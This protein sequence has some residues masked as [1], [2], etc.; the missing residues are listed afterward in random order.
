MTR[1][2]QEL[3]LQELMILKSE[4][5]SAEKST[6]LSYLMLLGGHLGIHRFYLKRPG[7]GAAQLALF[8]VATIFYFVMAIAS[9]TSNETLVILSVILFVLP[10]IALFIWIVV[11]LFLLPGM[12]RS[13]N[14]RIE[15]DILQEIDRHRHM[16]QLMG[17][18]RQDE[19]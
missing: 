15:Q 5:K 11:D 13:Y 9:E 16:E 18:D 3:S 10:A 17:R 14:E 1:T 19:Q 7:T 2:K 6:A 12:I 8:L 4:L